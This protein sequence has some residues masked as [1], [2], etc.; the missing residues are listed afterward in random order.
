M[1]CSVFLLGVGISPTTASQ[2]AKPLLMHLSEVLYH[3]GGHHLPQPGVCCVIRLMFLKPMHRIHALQTDS[4][5]QPARL[6]LRRR[7]TI[8]EPQMPPP[9]CYLAHTF[10]DEPCFSVLLVSTF[11][12]ASHSLHHCVTFRGRLRACSTGD[13]SV[14][15]WDTSSRHTWRTSLECTHKTEGGQI[16]DQVLKEPSWAGV[17]VGAT[18]EHVVGGVQAQELNLQ[19]G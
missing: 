14:C 6:A 5:S 12:C 8:W 18:D 16:I 17:C 3:V 1:V 9:P 13:H 11:T 19:A 7:E 10:Y 15:V 4:H 2:E